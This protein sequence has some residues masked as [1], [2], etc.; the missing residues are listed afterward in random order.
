VTDGIEE[1]I[2]D[3]GQTDAIHV[4]EMVSGGEMAHRANVIRIVGKGNRFRFW[5]NDQ[6]LPLCM[7]GSNAVS[8]WSAPGQCFTSEPVDEYVDSALGQGQI[9]LAAGTLDGSAVTVAFDDLVI[10]GPDQN[11]GK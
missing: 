10:V 2:S 7:R 6:S 4:S 11:T 8:M 5:V 3:W 1:I 9:A